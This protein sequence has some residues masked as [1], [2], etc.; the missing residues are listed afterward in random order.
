MANNKFRSDRERDPIAE[1]ARLI[2]EADPYRERAALDN[3]FR[4]ETT[5]ECHDEAPGVS[6]APQLW[7]DV[8]APEQAYELD[9]YRHNDEPY[10][11]D[12]S[13]NVSHEDYQAEAPGVRR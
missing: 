11:V 10:N 5:S 13:P 2:A 7:A 6:P 9:E 4:Q 12:N 3:R 8:R 1:L